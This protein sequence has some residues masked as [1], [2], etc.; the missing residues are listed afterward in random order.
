GRLVARETGRAGL[1][2][3]AAA[4]VGT[5]SLMLTPAMWFSGGQ[6]PW[7]ALGIL[8]AL[9]YAQVFRRDGRWPGLV[10]SAISAGVAGGVLAPRARR[11]PLVRRP[12]ALPA[13]RDG[14]PGGD[15]LDRRADVRLRGAAHGQH[16]Q[17][18]R[19]HGQPGRQPV[20]GGHHH[21]AVHPRDPD[22]GQSRPRG[23]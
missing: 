21:V 7:A 4:L 10:L 6:P 1:G 22:P 8:S 18:P 19:A 11:L 15:G 2:L 5:T 9:W 16:G 13:G 20:P 12:S 3:G 17:L 23:G 14:A